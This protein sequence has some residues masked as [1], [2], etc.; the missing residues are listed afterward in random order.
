MN[1]EMLEKFLFDG[2]YNAYAL[3]DGASIAGLRMKMYEMSPRYFC[4]FRGEIPDD[5]AENA[6]Y[7]VGLISGERFTEWLLSEKPGKHT[8]IFAKSRQSLIEMR[9]HFRELIMVQDESGKPMIF[10][11]YDPRVI[12]QFVPTCS[13]EELDAFF[14]PVDHFI[15]E[16]QNGDNYSVF[17]RENGSLSVKLLEIKGD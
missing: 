3:L 17:S 8:G 5:I 11:Y 10:R 9:R 15:A 1:K 14:G 6:P 16:T 12:S 2:Q 13:E 7:L 4:L